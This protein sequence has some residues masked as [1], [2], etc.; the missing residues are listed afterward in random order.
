MN[1]EMTRGLFI[2]LVFHKYEF[3]VKILCTS[4]P[5]APSSESKYVI[6][7]VYADLEGNAELLETAEFLQP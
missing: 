4:T 3:A 5:S 6:A 2:R 1:R 7:T